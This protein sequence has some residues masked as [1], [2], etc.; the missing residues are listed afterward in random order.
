MTSLTSINVLSKI[1]LTWW[2]VI[3]LLTTLILHL[4]Y[5]TIKNW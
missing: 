5:K 3:K 2:N 4:N 1:S